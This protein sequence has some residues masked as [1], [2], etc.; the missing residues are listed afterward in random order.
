MITIQFDAPQIESTKS[1][2]R[3]ISMFHF[4]S[5]IKSLNFLASLVVLTVGAQLAAAPDRSQSIKRIVDTIAPISEARAASAY[6]GAIARAGLSQHAN[7]GDLARP[8][9]DDGR[10]RTIFR[11]ADFVRASPFVA[12]A[13]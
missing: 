1:I 2:S 6:R 13:A 11:P 5:R 12:F 9:R 7:V 4:A 10:L 8:I 3:Q